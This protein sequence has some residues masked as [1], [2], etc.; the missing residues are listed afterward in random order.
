MA[1]LLLPRPY[2]EG[3]RIDLTAAH[4]EI[5]AGG[6]TLDGGNVGEVDMREVFNGTLEVLSINRG[7]E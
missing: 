2:R 6:P 4:L 3:S 1:V 5:S 7:H